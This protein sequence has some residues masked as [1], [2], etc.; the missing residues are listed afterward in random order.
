MR[1]DSCQRTLPSG[2]GWPTPPP[3]EA[4]LPS[5]PLC[6]VTAAR[7]GVQPDE[8]SRQQQRFH[9]EWG[10]CLKSR[11]TSRLQSLQ[12]FR[13]DQMT[14]VCSHAHI[15]PTRCFCKAELASAQP[16][17]YCHPFRHSICGPV[18]FKKPMLGSSATNYGP[19]DLGE[20]Q[21]SIPCQ[22]Q[23]LQQGYAP[24]LHW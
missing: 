16:S 8:V 1:G 3:P 10:S 12:S 24:V 18:R 13:Q 11:W 5:I 23:M 19:L 4:L 6:S 22:L 7:A 20:D 9:T 15:K 2:W 17:G 14:S 21:P